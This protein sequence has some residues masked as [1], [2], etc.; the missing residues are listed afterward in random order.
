MHPRASPAI[1]AAA[2]PHAT[3]PPPQPQQPAHSHSAASANAQSQ[4]NSQS[5]G[6]NDAG[7]GGY[8]NS[9][10]SGG[11]APKSEP[12]KK[13]LVATLA[14]LTAANI[15]G[16]LW[17]VREVEDFRDYADVHAPRF[18][19]ELRT[20]LP[21]G[22]LPPRSTRAVVGRV[23]VQLGLV[24]TPQ[25]DVDNTVAEANRAITQKIVQPASA[26]VAEN[27]VPISTE[28]EKVVTEAFKQNDATAK[29]TAAAPAP[30]VVAP[31][32]V[33][34]TPPPTPKPTP[35]P[36][37]RPSA[38]ASTSTSTPTPPARSEPVRA[39]PAAAAA[40][41]NTPS[42]ELRALL[43]EVAAAEAELIPF[44][45]GQR[46]DLWHALV[47]VEDRVMERG[48][49]RLISL[50]ADQRHTLETLATRQSRNQIRAHE[51]CT[52]P[53]HAEFVRSMKVEEENKWRR[54]LYDAMFAQNERMSA[55][56]DYWL[57]TNESTL[58]THYK[59]TVERLSNAAEALETGT[60][61]VLQKRL[62]AHR[63]QELRSA[64]AHRLSA[65]L[66][67]LQELVERDHASLSEPWRV[68]REV[69]ESDNTLR[70]AIAPIDERTVAEGVY[71]LPQLKAAFLALA[72]SLKVATFMPDEPAR[73]S[74]LR[75]AMA[76]LFSAMTLNEAGGV[77]LPPPPP[78]AAAMAAAP[79]LAATRQAS[80]LAHQASDYAHYINAST[81]LA[82]NS[83]ELA[84]AELERL[85][86]SRRAG[87]MESFLVE[88]RKTVQVQQAVR[89]VKMR[90]IAI[91]NNKNQA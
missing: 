27:I 25:Q 59:T 23:G 64:Q 2:H 12:S 49:R 85:H 3:Q 90:V 66:L 15:G 17:A 4:S 79:S 7:A 6:S 21:D 20:R 35:T 63:H 61:R 80:E 84:L 71:S 30:V 55:V 19:T 89:V 16:F 33:V 78:A 11:D 74:V 87:E 76:H 1:V 88:L 60:I 41:A 51:Y 62:A 58:R 5:H 18:M 54:K 40:A 69:A 28:I 67:S 53:A 47:A 36:A 46:Q 70:T 77:L 9:G 56:A 65:A 82:S 52:A 38:A 42:A 57:Q 24:E 83:P 86:P 68:I 32:V 14:M 72:P 39:A 44:V 75:Q 29:E 43:A 22:F 13:R 37:P 45:E 26:I 10:S 91:N 8:G 31:A 73:A 50:E 48:V 81:F 34:A